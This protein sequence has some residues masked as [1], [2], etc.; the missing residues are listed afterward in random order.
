MKLIM[1]INNYLNGHP[2]LRFFL[3]YTILF[4]MLILSLAMLSL[5]RIISTEAN[6]FF[7][8]NF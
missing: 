5:N 8:A 6:P 3:K 7:Y 1:K 4:T 2:N